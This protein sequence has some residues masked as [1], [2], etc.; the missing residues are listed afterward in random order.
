MIF[1][2]CVYC[3]EP[4][5]VSLN[6]DYLMLLK[7]GKQLV[8]KEICEKCGKAN[9]VEHRRMGG[10]TFGEDDPRAKKIDKFEALKGLKD[11]R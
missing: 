1:T 6:E 10:E 9:Y 4:I 11:G 8:S 7:K 3:S 2:E 5:F